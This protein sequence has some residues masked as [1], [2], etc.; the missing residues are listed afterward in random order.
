MLI[1]THGKCAWREIFGENLSG[2]GSRV[3]DGQGE[4][5]GQRQHVKNTK[6]GSHNR[7][8]IPERAPGQAHSRFEIATCR[9]PEERRA[10]ARLGIGQVVQIGEPVVHLGGNG[11]RLVAHAEADVQTGACPHIILRISAE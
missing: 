11:G 10:D 3:G 6:T 8:V 2:E 7:F 9:I 4:F 5:V 1:G